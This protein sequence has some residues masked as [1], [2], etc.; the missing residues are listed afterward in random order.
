LVSTVAVVVLV[1]LLAIA[2]AASFL[3]FSADEVQK[4]ALVPANKIESP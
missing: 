1:V 3:L 4:P 2:G